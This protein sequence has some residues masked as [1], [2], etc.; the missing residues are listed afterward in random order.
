MASNLKKLSCLPFFF[1]I[2][3]F[4]VTI[5]SAELCNPNDK[6]V[7]LK[8]KKAFNNP[9]ILTSWDPQTDC[10]HWYCVKCNRTT[11][12]IISLTIFAD[13]RLTGQIPPEVGDLPFL[14][15][16]ML[17]KLPNLTGPIQPT[18]A[19]LRNLVFLDLSWNGLSGEIPD[20]LST[21]KNLFILTLS[22]NKL[23]G[24]IPS[25]LSELPNLGGLRLDRNQ[26]TGQIPES[27]GYFSGEQ[28]PDLIL[29]HNQLS[30][31]IPS[32]LSR[33]NSTSIDLSRNKL[34]GDASM[35]F[36]A[37][38]MIQILDLSR[39]LLEF[40]LSEVVFPQSLTSLDLNHNKVYGGLPPVMTE[41]K[42][43]YLNVSYNR[44]C[45]PIP[46]GGDMQS[47]DLYSYFHNK[48]LCGA[49]LGD[50]K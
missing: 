32:S 22:F 47:F 44:L 39:N 11:H 15:T 7:L 30:G 31:K 12:R 5:S 4:F 27:F 20:S 38:K 2:F 21:L 23:T 29:S 25:S 13:D 34:E 40:N 16:L 1:L 17:H 49:P 36:G 43:Q 19:K 8:I 18:I 9:Y 48:C 26:L 33:L 41:L 24:E 6:K 28:A 42:L 45:G 14:Q 35:F 3:F 46:V 50:C 37:N 10:C